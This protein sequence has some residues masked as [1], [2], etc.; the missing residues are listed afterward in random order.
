MPWV[1]GIED[2]ADAVRLLRVLQMVR[3]YLFADANGKRTAPVNRAYYQ[4]V[5]VIEDRRVGVRDLV[6]RFLAP[7][8]EDARQLIEA[9]ADA[10]VIVIDRR[11]VVRQ[12]GVDRRKIG[13]GPHTYF[14]G[15]ERDHRR[16]RN[17]VERDHHGNVVAVLPEQVDYAQRRHSRAAVRFDKERDL[18][19]FSQMAQ[20]RVKR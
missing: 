14:I 9:D 11:Q 18:L 1:I 10:A 16:R 8:I 2:L 15:A 20:Q 17:A 19:L 4:R 13:K 6:L 12:R 3:Q 5:D 7:Q